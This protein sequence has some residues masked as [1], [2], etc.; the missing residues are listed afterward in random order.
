MMFFSTNSLHRRRSRLPS[1]AAGIH[2]LLFLSAV[3]LLA[4]AVLADSISLSF[5]SFSQ[6]NYGNFNFSHDAGGISLGALQITP[7]GTDNITFLHNKSGR[8][9]FYRP[10]RLWEEVSGG[11]KRI[12]SFNTSF[13][14]NVYRPRNSPV[15]GEGIAFLIAPDQGWPPTDSAGGFLGLTNATLD[16]QP[17]N[18]IVAVEFDNVK[19]SYDPAGDH[20]GLNINSVRS[21]VTAQLS[22]FGI[23]ISPATAVNYSIWIDYDGADR[24]IRVHMAQQGKPKPG[25]PVMS[26]ALD[27]GE[28]VNQNS[29][30]GFAAA[31]GTATYELNCVLAWN[32]TVEDL[33]PGKNRGSPTAWKIGAGAAAGAVSLAVATA[34]VWLLRK[35]TKKR[36]RAAAAETGDEWELE[37]TLKNLPGMAREF[38]YAELRKATRNFDEKMKLGQGGFGVVYRGELLEEGK[39]VAVKRFSRE[40]DM[41]SQDDFF[42]ELAVI[43]RLRHRNLVRLLGWCHNNGVLLLV[44]DYMPN[45][46]LDHHLY[47]GCSA[48]D[49]DR[50]LLPWN[51]RRQILAGAASAL[52]YLHNEY[53]ECVVHRDIKS[54]NI[55][56]DADFNARLGDFGLAIVLDS[57]KTSYVDLDPAGIPGTVGYIAP[58]CFHTSKATR[59]SDV[60]AFGAVVLE[61]V[62]G[63]RPSSV[64]LP[65]FHFL[66]D[67]VWDLHR[68]GKIL[69][70]VDQ[71]LAGD[72]VVEE[73]GRLLLLG[74]A[75][76]HPLPGKRPRAADVIQ[77]LSGELPAP[78]VPPMKPAFVWPAAVPGG[79]WLTSTSSI[80]TSSSERQQF[81]VSK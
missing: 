12:A 28:H 49:G 74:L 37:G 65:G 11:R 22:P 68:E 34:A 57:G 9:I 63:R 72:Y 44:Y 43:N 66:V 17:S 78:E 53:N 64:R 15:P 31:T 24:M 3:L 26:A 7:D 46:S 33:L 51:R 59:E 42:K 6:D 29:Y 56:L 50:P 20:V 19:Q 61:V 13:E 4:S 25:S 10:F 52:H 58:E 27:L 71:R 69:D 38:E 80:M 77:M 14:I 5:P 70:A 75:C 1:A 23:E 76:S 60:F 45:G 30:F 67:W 40:E 39:T 55:L 35:R 41:K 32:L 79:G 81:N 18:R 48:P 62:A 36:E 2:L 8:V 21:N 54:S 47:V 16:G 73:A